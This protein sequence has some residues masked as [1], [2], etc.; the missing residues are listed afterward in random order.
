MASQSSCPHCSSNS[1]S[2]SGYSQGLLSLHGRRRQ[3]LRCLSCKR[4]FTDNFSNLSFR[5]KKTDPALNGKIFHLCINGIPNRAIARLLHVSEHCVRIRILRMAQQALH[6]HSHKTRQL[7]ITEGICF[8]G[9]ENFAGSQYDVNNIQQAIGER[10]L[11]IYDFNLA[12]MNRKGH[13]S[14]WQK[15]RLIEINSTL[16]R[17]DRSA[18]RVATREILQR[19]Y[20]KRAPSFQFRL[21]SDEHFQ[22]RR[23]IRRDL[24][25]LKIKHET[26]SAKACRNFQ[27]ILFPVNH[28]D[29]IIRKQL[30]AFTRE[31][32]SFSKTHAAMCQKYALFMVHKNYMAPQFTKLQVRRPEAHKTS[33]AQHLKLETRILEFRDVFH[34]RSREKDLQDLN[35]DFKCFWQSQIP[36]KYLRRTQQLR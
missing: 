9:V 23:A 15:Q 35:R 11:F 2:R 5:F 32:I 30:A 36:D 4:R 18:I 13:M 14:D 26:V 22:Y 6:F 3:R 31:T 19:L 34:K 25:H 12:S 1:V 21:L 27:N 17:Y 8:D 29:L 16:G 24:R 20:E 28:A 7:L 10:S 33:P